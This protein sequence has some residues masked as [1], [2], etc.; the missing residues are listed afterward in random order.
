[1]VGVFYRAPEPGAAPFVEAGACVREDDTVGLIEVMKLFHAVKSGVRGRIAKI[2][3]ENAEL[4]EYGQVL[5]LLEPEGKPAEP[6][7]T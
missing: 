7:G 6:S 3:V 2:C 4:V 5:F 1:M